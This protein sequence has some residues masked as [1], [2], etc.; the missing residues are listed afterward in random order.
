[1]QLRF[2]DEGVRGGKAVPRGVQFLEASRVRTPRRA[3]SEMCA[4]CLCGN[5]TL[6]RQLLG[7]AGRDSASRRPGVP[8]ELR[9]PLRARSAAVPQKETQ[10]ANSRLAEQLPGCASGR[11]SWGCRAAEPWRRLL[12]RSSDFHLRTRGSSC[13][14]GSRA[15]D[16]GSEGTSSFQRKE[17]SSPAPQ[18]LGAVAPSAPGKGG[19]VSVRL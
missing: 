18:A 7:G 9:G 14:F 10:S 6:L 15:A 13:G 5:Q 17:K 19:A 4:C 12:A 8:R 1:M 3:A 11:P 2:G 16:R